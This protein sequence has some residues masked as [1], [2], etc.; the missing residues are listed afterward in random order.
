[1]ANEGDAFDFNV[2]IEKKDDTLSDAAVYRAY[3]YTVNGQT[4]TID[5]RRKD[6]QTISLKKGETAVIDD[7][8]DGADIIVT[9]A[10]SEKHADEGYTLKTT[11]TEMNEKPNIIGYT[12]PTSAISDRLKSP[13]RLRERG[14]T[15]ATAR[16]S[17]LT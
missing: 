1:M 3:T 5:F 13:K 9:E 15:R 14:A 7:V 2:R 16:R 4:A 8:P 10:M 12:L 11:Q 6:V 17:N